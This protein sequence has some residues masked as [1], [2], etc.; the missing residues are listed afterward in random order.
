MDFWYPNKDFLDKH[1]NRVPGTIFLFYASHT[2]LTDRLHWYKKDAILDQNCFWYGLSQKILGRNHLVL[3]EN[4]IKLEDWVE[5]KVDGA[6]QTAQT[7]DVQ[8]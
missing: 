5:S 2:I 6:N 3:Y 1:E 4:N 8:R 7:Y